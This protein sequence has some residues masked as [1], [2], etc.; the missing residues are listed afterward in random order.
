MAVI[1]QT[2]LRV[3]ILFASTQ[4]FVRAEFDSVTAEA[5]EINVGSV[6]APV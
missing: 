3:C 2:T 1:I 5:D 4:N 6:T